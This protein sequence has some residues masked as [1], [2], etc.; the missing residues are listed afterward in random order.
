MMPL[1][2][3]RR[4]HRPRATLTSKE[5][6]VLEFYQKPDFA[7]WRIAIRS[8]PCDGYSFLT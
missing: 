7:A 8:S 1:I 6:A 3:H 4:K 5:K 2:H